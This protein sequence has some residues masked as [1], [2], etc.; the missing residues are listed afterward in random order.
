M[1]DPT[2]GATGL[3]IGAATG[4]GPLPGT[5]I[6]E[7]V[8][9]VAGELPVLPYLPELAD[10]GVG[11]DTVGRTLAQLVD[12]HA[13]VVPSGWR[14]C[15][16][17]GR[18]ARRGKDFRA[19]DLDAGEQYFGAAP[20]IKIQLLGPWTLAARLELPNGHRAVS[21]HGATADLAASLGQGLRDYLDELRSR[22][23]S[24]TIVVQLDEPDL[25]LVLDGLLPTPS[26]FGTVRSV[27]I[28]TV[29]RGLTSFTSAV[30][31]GPLVISGVPPGPLW[32]MLR[33]ASFRNLICQLGDLTAEPAGVSAI[34]EAVESS[35]TLLLRLD[36]AGTLDAA[37]RTLVGAWRRIGFPP[38]TLPPSV[39]PV[40]A[41]AP[42][43]P[44]GIAAVLGV[45]RQLA[46]ALAD[47]PESWI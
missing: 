29:E 26:G 47:P 14:V 36:A 30:P 40:A 24:S 16:R 3:P 21:D 10:R 31:D 22:L 27:S 35:A 32:T 34:G 7:A 6:G 45:A 28:D 4:L 9:T 8:R 17:P 18:D 43:D 39:I 2:A 37:G 46:E 15:S 42:G 20:A 23:P 41:P 44:A 5:D 38:E 1:T 33:T 25:P 19:W 11:A 12:I 13:E